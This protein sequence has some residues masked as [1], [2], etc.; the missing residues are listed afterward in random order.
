MGFRTVS[1]VVPL[2]EE[3]AVEQAAEMLGELIIYSV[4]AAT[5]LFE[6]RRQVRNDQRKENTQNNRLE[7]LENE[8][9]ELGIQLEVQNGQM[10]EMSRQLAA[11]NASDH[12]K[13]PSTIKDSKS[14][15]VVQVAKGMWFI[16]LSSW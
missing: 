4:A 7:G 5:I 12:T 16:F 9:K 15:D 6:Y 2:N 10:R 1:E 8:V 13:L 11:L 14:G 3:M